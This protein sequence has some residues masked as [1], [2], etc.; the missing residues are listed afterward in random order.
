MSLLLIFSASVSVRAAANETVCFGPTPQNASFMKYKIKL[1]SGYRNSPAPPVIYDNYLITVSNGTLYKINKAD[2]SVESSVKLSGRNFYSLV[3]PVAADGK[4]FV[5]LDGGIVQALDFYTLKSLWIY[6]APLG[7]QALC[8]I[9]YDNGFIYTGFWNGETEKASFICLDASDTDNKKTAHWTYISD[10]GFYFVRAVIKEDFIIFGSDNGSDEASAKGKIIALNKENGK[11]AS[12]LSV[13]GDIRSGIFY[14]GETDCFYTVSKGG[15]LYKFSLDENS[16]ILHMLS[17]KSLPGEATSTPA[18][19]NKRLY[20]VY[21]KDGKGEFAVF[22]AEKM[23]MIYTCEM[24]G[25]CQGDILVNNYYEKE[26]GFVYIYAS[27]NSLPGGIT[28][29]K[30]KENQTAPIKTELFAPPEE[31]SQYSIS[32]VICDNEGILYYKNDS[33]CIFAVCEENSNL[34]LFTILADFFGLI[35]SIINKIINFCKTGAFI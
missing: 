20:S 7:G 13:T 10:G 30:D 31:F 17:E 34:P 28:L 2:G 4:I 35:T 9:V 25:Y 19:Y 26:N 11:T 24:N 14:D 15:Y 1:G 27:Y 32:P 5:Q 18:V 6:N 12:A 33:G 23:N 16:G 8:P 3:S 29:F 21:S 22:D